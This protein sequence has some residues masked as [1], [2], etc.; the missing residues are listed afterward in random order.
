MN[1]EE[2]EGMLIDYIDGTLSAPDRIRVEQELAVNEEARRTY[3]QLR[4]VMS[5]MDQSK[6]LEPGTSLKASFDKIIPPSTHCSAALSCGGVR[7]PGRLG[8]SPG[9]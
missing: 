4:E 1:K 2:L 6:E 5:S 3:E 9:S 7:S 8:R